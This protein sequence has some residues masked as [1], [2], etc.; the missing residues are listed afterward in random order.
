VT[1]GNR[2]PAAA[3]AERPRQRGPATPTRSCRGACS[4]RRGP[5]G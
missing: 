3:D 4:S 5:P 2:P 1:C